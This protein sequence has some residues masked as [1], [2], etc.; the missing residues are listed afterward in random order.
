M[1]LIVNILVNL[2]NV[3]GKLLSLNG[4]LKLHLHNN[5]I[6]NNSIW[7]DIFYILYDFSIYHGFLHLH[8]CI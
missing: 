8:L 4:G 5:Y 2:F 3:V 6:H 1:P 7:W